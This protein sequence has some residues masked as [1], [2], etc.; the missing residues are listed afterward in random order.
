MQSLNP[1]CTDKKGQQLKRDNYDDSNEEKIVPLLSNGH[2]LLYKKSPLTSKIYKKILVTLGYD[3]DIVKDEDQFL[4]IIQN[5]SYQYVL[6]DESIMD[7][8]CLVAEF[9]KDTGA[10][11]IVFSDKP[12]DR[13]HCCITVGLDIGK[14]ALAEMLLR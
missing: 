13:S 11:P 1:L 8:D 10:T 5:T 9:V 4:G 14:E 6:M 2:I 12:S 7:A 3:V